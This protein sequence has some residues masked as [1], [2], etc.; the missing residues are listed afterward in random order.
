MSNK[1]IYSIFKTNQIPDKIPKF[2]NIFFKDSDLVSYVVYTRLLYNG[3][4]TTCVQW[5]Y[6]KI[7][8]LLA[9]EMDEMLLFYA[10]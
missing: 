10:A 6:S 9:E 7:V 2:L 4:Y 1:R 3:C 8:R 5:F